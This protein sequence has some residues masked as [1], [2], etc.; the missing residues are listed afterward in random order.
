MGNCIKASLYSSVLTA[1]E[2]DHK[3]AT[4]K[5]SFAGKDLMVNIEI[6]LI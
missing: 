2:V 6:V 1:L 4:V 3:E 5:Q